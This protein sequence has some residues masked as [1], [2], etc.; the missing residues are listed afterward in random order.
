MDRYIADWTKESGDVPYEGIQA[1][2]THTHTHRRISFVDWAVCTSSCKRV[3]PGIKRRRKLTAPSTPV[4]SLS[5]VTLWLIF[6]W[7]KKKG[8]GRLC[9]PPS[10][11]FPPAVSSLSYIPRKRHP[12]FPDWWLASLP[13]PGSHLKCTASIQASLCQSRSVPVSM[14]YM[15]V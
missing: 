6:S 8:S 2:H 12:L 15:F 3:V 5:H 7:K 1:T 13:T 10:S 9:P 11:D 14:A 4:Y